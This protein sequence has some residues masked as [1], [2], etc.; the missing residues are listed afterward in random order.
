MM[1][2]GIEGFVRVLDYVHTIDSMYVAEHAF[3]DVLWQ[4]A[5]CLDVLLQDSV[6]G[7]SQQLGISQPGLDPTMTALP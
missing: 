7:S 2:L 5:E 1:A 4:V 3:L 6:G